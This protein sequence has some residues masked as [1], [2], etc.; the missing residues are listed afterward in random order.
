MASQPRVELMIPEDSME[1]TVPREAPAYHNYK[2][3]AGKMERCAPPA[4]PKVTL[5]FLPAILMI[6][7]LRKPHEKDQFGKKSVKVMQLLFLSYCSIMQ[8]QVAL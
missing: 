8:L 5:L 6:Y 1:R 2:K 7:L 4:P 3:L